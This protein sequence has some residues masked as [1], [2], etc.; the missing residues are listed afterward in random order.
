MKITVRA[1]EDVGF[2]RL[3]TVELHWTTGMWFWTKQHKEI[4]TFVTDDGTVFR[5]RNG[6]R[7]HLDLEIDLERALETWEAQAEFRRAGVLSA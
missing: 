6:L 7:C 5:H 1:V 2:L 3:V 4:Q